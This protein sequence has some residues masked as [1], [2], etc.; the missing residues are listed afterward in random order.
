[1]EIV[2]G[3]PCFNCSDTAKAKKNIDPAK[4]QNAPPAAPDAHRS[5]NLQPAQSNAATSFGVAPTSDNQ[6]LAFGQRGTQL[7]LLA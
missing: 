4:D 3:Y 7:N 1:M 2:N 5:D 6:P